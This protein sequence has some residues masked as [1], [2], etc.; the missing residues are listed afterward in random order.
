MS[1]RWRV[2]RRKQRGDGS[3]VAVRFVTVQEVIAVARKHEGKT[4]P[5]IGGEASFSV[6]VENERPVFYPTSTGDRRPAT[7]I[8]QLEKVVDKFN[9]TGS[10]KTTDY[11]F[12]G[13]QNLSYI[14]RLVEIA[15]DPAKGT[16]PG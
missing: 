7:N 15:S 14:L 10:L 8:T 5:T 12:T 1:P 6:R 9:R 4:L 11:S 16:A 13:S 2:R 3:L